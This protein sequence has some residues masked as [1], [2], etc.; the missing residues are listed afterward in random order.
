[1]TTDTITVEHRQGLVRWLREAGHSGR[2][3]A[4]LLGVGK[5]VVFWDL[6]RLR[7]AGLL[8]E[9]DRITGLDGKTRPARRPSERALNGGDAR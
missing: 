4:G 8:D 7:A 5:S 3:I 2:L 6:D 1:M 9:P